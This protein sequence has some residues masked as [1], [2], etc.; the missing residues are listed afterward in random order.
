MSPKK[1]QTSSFS[2]C[3]PK[4]CYSGTYFSG[5]PAVPKMRRP[6]QP[7]SEE[8]QLIGEEVVLADIGE[9]MYLEE[10]GCDFDDS[11]LYPDEDDESFDY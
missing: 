5:R 7:R 6:P 3:M 9:P 2:K 1:K 11:D 4:N 8:E 10:C